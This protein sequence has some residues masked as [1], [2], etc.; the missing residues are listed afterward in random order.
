[1]TTEIE[2]IGPWRDRVFGWV[3][4]ATGE[5]HPERWVTMMSAEATGTDGQVHGEV[6]ICGAEIHVPGIPELR[7]YIL[8][9]TLK[10]NMKKQG[11][12]AE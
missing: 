1:M 9:Q 2:I 5:H 7:A 12:W 10:R 11:V 4:T 6:V 3:D 8:R